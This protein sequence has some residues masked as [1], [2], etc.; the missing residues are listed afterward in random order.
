MKDFHWF[1]LITNGIL[2]LYIGTMLYVAYIAY[3]RRSGSTGMDISQ[4]QQMRYESIYNSS[5][6][7]NAS[8]N[9]AKP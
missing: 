3:A 6:D 5:P 1:K 4:V 8:L 7:L 2:F 9:A